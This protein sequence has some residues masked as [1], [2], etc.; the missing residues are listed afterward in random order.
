MQNIDFSK[1]SQQFGH[2]KNLPIE[3]YTNAVP[4]ILIGL[5]N[6]SLITVNKVKEGAKTEPVAISTK[7]GWLIYGTSDETNSCKHFNFQICACSAN[8]TDSNIQLDELVKKFDALDSLGICTK[9]PIK[10]ENYNRALKLLDD[11]TLHKN[12][13]SVIVEI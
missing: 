2:L 7:Q 10:S 6:C 12:Y 13:G 4:Q 1:L 9:D 11:L 3:S 8:N 5:N